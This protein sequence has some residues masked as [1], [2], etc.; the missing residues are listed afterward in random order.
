MELLGHRASIHLSSL[1]AAKQL[2]KVSVQFYT[3]TGS[4]ESFSCFT[5]QLICGIVCLL[6]LAI[7]VGV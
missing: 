6:N 3:P 1:V 2:A 7:L 4:D 5:S